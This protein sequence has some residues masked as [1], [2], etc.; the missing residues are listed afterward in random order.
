[1]PASQPKELG[2]PRR[3]PVRFSSLSMSA[4]Q[5][6]GVLRAPMDVMV[7]FGLLTMESNKITSSMVLPKLPEQQPLPFYLAATLWYR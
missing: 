4:A 6:T 5:D 7:Q 1:M 3:T 2:S